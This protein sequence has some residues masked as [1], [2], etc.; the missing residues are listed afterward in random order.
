VAATRHINLNRGLTDLPLVA[1]LVRMEK[2]QFLRPIQIGDVVDADSEITFT[3]DRSC[4]VRVTVRSVGMFRGDPERRLSTMAFLWFV[5]AYIH[6][7]TQALTASRMMPPVKMTPEEHKSGIMRYNKQKSDRV[8]Y[9]PS[10]SQPPVFIAPPNPTMKLFDTDTV[11]SSQST[12]MY[13]VNLDDCDMFKNMR[14]GA[15]MK[16]ADELA[17]IT[18]F[19]HCKNNCVTATVDA[20][21]FNRSIPLGAY[22]YMDGYMTYTSGKSMEVEIVVHAGW[23]DLATGETVMVYNVVNAIFTFV[24]IDGKGRPLN[25]RELKLETDDERKVFE[26]GQKRHELRVKDRKAR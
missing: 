4:E 11:R 26:E 20:C 16:L 9:A 22:V 10:K 5:A 15:I 1:V 7:E 21:N 14:G 19:R 13:L 12:Y 17:G 3:S 6:P 18:A 25:V 2:V 23:V 8:H 24:S